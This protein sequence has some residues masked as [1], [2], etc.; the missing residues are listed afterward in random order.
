MQ[1]RP[2]KTLREQAK[3]K[4]KEQRSSDSTAVMFANTVAQQHAQAGE[5]C[6]LEVPND[7]DAVENAGRD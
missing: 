5:S 1:V 2:A 3:P 6:G 7:L 4:S